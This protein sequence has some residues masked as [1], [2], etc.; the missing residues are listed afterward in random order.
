MDGG[1]EGVCDIIVA[2]A[3]VVGVA[4]AYALARRGLSVVLVDRN[5]GPAQGASFANGAQLSY[6]YTDA[7]GSPSLVARLPSLLLGADPLFK[8]TANFDPALIA[9]GLRF[10]A[11]STEAGFRTNTLATLK[12]A[13]ESQAALHALLQ[14]HPIAFGHAAPG[15]MHMYFDAQSLAAAEQMVRLKADHGAVQQVLSPGEAR[16]L[17]PALAGARGLYGVVHSPGDEVGDPRRFCEGLLDH[18]KRTYGVRTVFGLDIAKARLSGDRAVVTGRCGRR[19]SGRTLVV[20]TG[21]GT[22]PLLASLGVRAPILPMRGY[23]F[24]APRGPA[25]PRVSVT[26]AKRKIVFCALSGQIRVAGGAELGAHRAEAPQRRMAALTAAARASLPDAAAY[27]QAGAGWGGL[28]PM[29]PTSTPIIAKARER[30]VLNIGH[31]ALGWTLAM[32]SAERAAA[33]VVGDPPN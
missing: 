6:A 16:A 3:G 24:T 21:V 5:A 9:W 11:A 22:G 32:G 17:E 2:G 15:K 12:L 18:L 26:D 30:L 29:T 33:L 25:P 13:L 19:V 28:R 23:S 10:L 27:D 14:R 7:L 8:V 20:A 1:E 4:T 31:G